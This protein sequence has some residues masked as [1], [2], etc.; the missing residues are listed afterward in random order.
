M[1]ASPLHA[2]LRRALESLRR[3]DGGFATT[4]GG[5]SEVEPTVMAA[6]ALGGAASA[7]RWLSRRQRT[8]GGFVE[9]DRRPVGPTGAALAAL[10]LDGE[11]ARRAIDYA[12]SRRGLP[13]PE[14]ADQSRRGWGWTS[15]ARSFVEP[16]C[17]VLI[18]A[19]RVPPADAR[20]RHEAVSVLA[21]RQCVDG[22]WNHGIITVLDEHLPGYVQTSALALIALERERGPFVRTGLEFLRR[23]WGTE[24]G[25]LTTAQVALAF[26]LHGMNQHAASARSALA[27]VARRR[28]F[29]GRTVGLAW[30]VLATGSDDLIEPLRGRA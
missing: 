13:P 3:P 17:R 1:G 26:H 5:S 21:E 6:L 16:T 28:S 25:G 11:R 8:D 18:A 19:K 9:A 27:T 15:E 12:V 10:V 23:S 14:A 2:E 4:A 24:P 20:V 29:L 30:A 22:G 7:R